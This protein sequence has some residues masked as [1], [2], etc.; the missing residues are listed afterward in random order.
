MD[1]VELLTSK[2]L[3]PHPAAWTIRQNHVEHT[4][5]QEA[6]IKPLRV[7]AADTLTDEVSQESLWLE[8]MMFAAWHCGQRWEQEAG[9]GP[10]WGALPGQRYHLQAKAK[11][12]RGSDLIS[13]VAVMHNDARSL[14]AT[15]S[16]LQH[17]WRE[18]VFL[19]S[20]TVAELY[21]CSR[22]P[23]VRY[24]QRC[25]ANGQTCCGGQ[26]T[27]SSKCNNIHLFIFRGAASL[28]LL[29]FYLQLLL[30]KWPR[31]RSKSGSQPPTIKETFK[32]KKPEVLTS[33][34]KHSV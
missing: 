3:H 29:C 26:G 23:T 11:W 17:F 4:S 31:W 8:M 27:C 16:I 32:S 34:K 20:C 18:L 9:G 10:T 19:I 28:R 2:T 14:C 21:V 24:K 33:E 25:G 7:T 5:E 22:V 15:R 6:L 1:L 30:R 13:R 12:R